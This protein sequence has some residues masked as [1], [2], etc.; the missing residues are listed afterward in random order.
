MS[1]YDTNLTAPG[2]VV[3]VITWTDSTSI[4][5]FTY[6]VKRNTTNSL[7]GAM[8]VGTNIPAGT[9][10]F[11]DSSVTPATRYYYFVEV[12]D[13]DTNT[14]VSDS[15]E[16]T[17]ALEKTA[18]TNHYRSLDADALVYDPATDSFM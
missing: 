1:S 15:A 8:P 7:A 10:N 16:V 17:T 6:T 3:N 12:T 13:D 5:T 9:R 4:G 14:A 11:T 2:G 18:M